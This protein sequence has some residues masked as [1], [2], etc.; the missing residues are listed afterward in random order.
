MKLWDLTVSFRCMKTEGLVSRSPVT[1]VVVMWCLM[2]RE[3]GR[4]GEQR[5]GSH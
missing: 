1:V 5:E 3:G 2:K 4:E